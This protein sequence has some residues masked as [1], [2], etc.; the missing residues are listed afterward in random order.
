MDGFHEPW[1]RSDDMSQE[2]GCIKWRWYLLDVLFAAVIKDALRSS[3]RHL[4]LMNLV[5]L[6]Y[7]ASESPV[8][9]GDNYPVA[10]R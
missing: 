9:V 1:A 5:Y 2:L 10:Y 4:L 6:S 7:C 3:N 8:V